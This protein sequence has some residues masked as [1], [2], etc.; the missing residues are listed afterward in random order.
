MF[1]LSLL[2]AFLPVPPSLQ[3]LFITLH[4]FPPGP[5]CSQFLFITLATL[6]LPSPTPNFSSSSDLQHLLKP[7]SIPLRSSVSQTSQRLIRLILATSILPFPHKTPPHLKLYDMY[8]RK[9]EHH[10]PTLLSLHLSSTFP[11]NY[12]SGFC[13]HLPSLFHL[14]Y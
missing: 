12:Y 7:R 5:P 1:S 3:F 8:L 10:P 6:L 9:P 2:R 14:T 4:A 13:C 11:F